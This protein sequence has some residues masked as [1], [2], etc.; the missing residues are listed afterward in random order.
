V[1]GNNAGPQG[2]HVLVIFKPVILPWGVI[3]VNFRLSNFRLEDED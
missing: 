2:L 3:P 1:Y